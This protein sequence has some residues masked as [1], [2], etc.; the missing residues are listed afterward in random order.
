M[1]HY[2]LT[3]YLN[4]HLSNLFA[5]AWEPKDVTPLKLDIP[6]ASQSQGKG[7]LCFRELKE[8]AN[9]LSTHDNLLTSHYDTSC[10]IKEKFMCERPESNLGP[11]RERHTF[12]L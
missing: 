1:L 11:C 10:A 7:D 5:G 4:N 3:R 6:M 2:Y 9:S 12:Y 8:A